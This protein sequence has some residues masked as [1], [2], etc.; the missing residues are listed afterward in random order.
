MRDISDQLGAAVEVEGSIVN[1]LKDERDDA[2][3]GRAP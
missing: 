3:E 1:I 2:A